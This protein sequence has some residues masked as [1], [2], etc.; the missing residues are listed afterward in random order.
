MH[1]KIGP[2]DIY[3][4][5]DAPKGSECVFRS[6]GHAELWDPWTGENRPLHVL[7]QTPDGT[8]VRMPLENYEAQVIVFSPSRAP[9]A[10]ETTDLDE[11]TDVNV[12]DD[13]VTVTGL[14]SRPGRK[15]ALV[16]REGRSV[17]VSGQAPKRPTP[18]VL[19]GPWDFELKPTL[20]NRW[21]DFRL[22]VT[23]PMIGPEAR[24]F[25]Y[26]QEDRAHPGWESPE[27]DDSHWPRVTYGFG[28]KFWKL[29][30]LPGDMDPAPLE[31]ALAELQEVDPAVPVHVGGKEYTWS[32]YAFSWRWGVEGDP[33]HQGYHGLKEN[34]TDDFIALGKPKG[35][36]N[37]TL[38]V[39]EDAGTRYYLWTS[40]VAVR[41]TEAKAVAGGLRP[42]AVYVNSERLTGLDTV[43]PLNAG[44]H[45]L[46]LRFDEPGRGHFVFEKI[47]APELSTPTPTPLAMS[48]YDRPGVLPYDVRCG[49]AKPIGWYRFTAAPGLR[50]M[51]VT[52][53]GVPQGWADG[54]PVRVEKQQ[55][56]ASG[57]T[58]YRMALDRPM[59][60]A[61]R[62]AL[63]IEQQRG[64]YGGSTLPEPVKL[65]CGPGLMTA[66]DWS[67]GSALECYSGGAWY[68]KTVNLAA[69]QI[70]GRVLLNLGDVVATAEV[71]VNGR[72]SGVC[73]A[74]P[75]TMD[76]SDLVKAGE[77]R[78]EILVYNTLANHYLTI[79]TRYRGPL[80]CGLLG[81]VTMGTN[82]TV[83]LS[84]PD[85][86]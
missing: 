27:F 72:M 28:P 68:R 23:D 57:A 70:R 41:D 83:K 6:Q 84:E 73:V 51:R 11:V 19:D 52:C 15:T 77:N 24:I 8:R 16:R 17:T 22:P 81:P 48:W 65:E 60:G 26:A 59:R 56:L 69:D 13:T 79:P 78:I 64:F 5:M 46:L 49:D 67:Q 61:A 50:A 63:R 44:A 74:P 39:Q 29:G 45:R 38:Y 47:G 66:G 21:G 34:V 7:S 42:A 30:P 86:H 85:T 31:A 20:D 1:R 9:A 10:V 58:Q 80:R 55:E 2:R 33:G 75:W 37:E 82:P 71:W 25:K 4:V 32:P 62:V 36:L 54:R 14:A 3:L 12:C 35:G 18:V 53:Y 40:V 43:V 76:V